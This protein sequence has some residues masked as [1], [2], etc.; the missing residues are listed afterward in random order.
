MILVLVLGIILTLSFYAADLGESVQSAK[1]I[2]NK[3][4]LKEKQYLI[5]DSLVP[6][7]TE[8]LKR[9]DTSYD[10]LSDL[11]AKPYTFETPLGSVSI[12]IVDE[13]R[14]LNPN[15][16]TKYKG[17]SEVFEK[18]ITYLEV[19]REL[20]DRILIWTGQE[21][22]SL[23]TDYLPKG[24]PL[25]STYEIELFWEKKEDLYGAEDREGL[26]EFL[27]VFSKGK[28]NIN[29]APLLVLYSLDRDIDMELAKRIADYRKEKPFK[30]LKDLLM[31]EGMT[32]DILYRIQNF[33]NV[34]SSVFRIEMSM[35]SQGVK[36]FLTV[37]YDRDGNKI[38]FKELR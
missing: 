11:W 18:L 2:V 21:E 1:E 26:F 28:V 10:A 25:D 34:K 8:L 24:K 27:T 35:E 19:D 16:I 32:L 37:V 6:K 15:Y 12:T 29:T 33:A 22:G 38:L 14:Y 3:V 20:L 4:Y 17:L 13:D 23:N 5:L 31:V 36:T 9:E 7:I 30:Q